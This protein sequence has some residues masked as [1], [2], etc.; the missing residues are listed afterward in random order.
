MSRL[1]QA[2]LLQ[3]YMEVG[4]ANAKT[5][6]RAARLPHAQEMET[7]MGE[8]LVAG[9]DP[10]APWPRED[11]AK[12]AEKARADLDLAIEQQKL[13]RLQM[14]IQM[15]DAEMQLEMGGQPPQ[16]PPMQQ[17]PPVQQGGG[18]PAMPPQQAQEM[19]DMMAMNVGQPPVEGF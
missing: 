2:Q 1:A 9:L 8:Q 3:Q 12:L 7:E 15:R 13:A 11:V 17:G 19:G 18:Q 16:P 5:S 10:I 14:R 6:I 4:A